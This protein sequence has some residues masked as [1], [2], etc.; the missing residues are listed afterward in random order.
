MKIHE[1]ESKNMNTAFQIQII[2]WYANLVHGEVSE[3]RSRK[4]NKPTSNNYFQVKELAKKHGLNVH[5]DGARVFN[6]ATALGVSVAQITQHVD[7]V[8]ICL[9]KVLTRLWERE[10]H[11]TRWH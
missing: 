1:Y 3:I 10:Y 11:L 7:S 6:A 9:S 4:Q 8:N 5:L 2:M